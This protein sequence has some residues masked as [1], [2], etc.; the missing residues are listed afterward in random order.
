MNRRSFL[1]LCGLVTSG[2][3]LGVAKAA[4]ATVPINVDFGTAQAN[5]SV[6]AGGRAY[7][8]RRWNGGLAIVCNADG[9]WIKAGSYGTWRTNIEE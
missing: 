1:K 7:R 8:I 3:V 6:V 5:I 2:G 4:M 9:E